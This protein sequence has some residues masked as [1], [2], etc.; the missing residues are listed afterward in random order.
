MYQQQQQDETGKLEKAIEFVRNRL[1]EVHTKI[2]SERFHHI[3]AGGAEWSCESEHDFHYLVKGETNPWIKAGR[4]LKDEGR[5]FNSGWTGP[6]VTI[7]YALWRSQYI[8]YGSNAKFLHLSNGDD[9]NL[10]EFP[11]DWIMMRGIHGYLQKSNNEYVIVFP[12]MK[13]VWNPGDDIHL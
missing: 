12:Y 7:N 8:T 13:Q 5:V 2:K 4:V 6:C 11:F 10:L 1:D 3:S 9:Q